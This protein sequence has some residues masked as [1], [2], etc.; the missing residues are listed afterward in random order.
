MSQQL[1]NVVESTQVNVATFTTRGHCNS[2]MHTLNEPASD[3]TDVQIEE[4]D[5]NKPEEAVVNI[6]NATINTCA[7]N[8]KNSSSCSWGKS[9]Q[10]WMFVAMG[11]ATLLFGLITF[12]AVITLRTPIPTWQRIVYITLA[13][14][15]NAIVFTCYWITICTPAGHVNKEAWSV[16][17]QYLVRHE[18]GPILEVLD[19]AVE[20]APAPVHTRDGRTGKVRY[21]RACNALK[22]DR[23]HHCSRCNA[24]IAR[25]D[26]HCPWTGRCIGLRNHKLFY[27]FTMY[28]TM[29][30]IFYI[31]S[32]L[33]LVIN[34]FDG[35]YSTPTYVEV[36]SMVILVVTALFG[37]LFVGGLFLQHTYL[38]LSNKTTFERLRPQR[39][40]QPIPVGVVLFD[41]GIAANW[42][43][44][45]GNNMLLWFVPIPT[46]Y[47]D[48][49]CS[50]RLNSRV[51]SELKQKKTEDMN[52]CAA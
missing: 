45:M 36:F 15:L 18:T 4:N 14:V 16:S 23:S 27:L 38:I 11:N 35:T 49:G 46:K 30:A 29:L 9:I 51:M 10:R 21:C 17:E 2:V 31:C 43:A 22:A 26:H 28:G 6:P 1:S 37:G 52:A 33:P 12:I 7:P 13:C 3:F 39:T 40:A 42:R 50:F 5:S 19:T 44:V 41:L 24:C 32:I 25:F 48:G 47:E 8:K 20:A 34:D